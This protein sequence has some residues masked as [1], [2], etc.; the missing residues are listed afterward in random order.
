MIPGSL[1]PASLSQLLLASLSVS[2]LMPP[3][4]FATGGSVCMLSLQAPKK[5]S[6][7][8]PWVCLGHGFFQSG[9]V[10]AELTSAVPVDF[11]AMAPHLRCEQC[12]LLAPSKHVS[13]AVRLWEAH[14]S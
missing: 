5:A 7:I 6:A 13:A 1:G 14:V 2:P 8:N 12:F 4:A 11:L 3:P 9:K 10:T